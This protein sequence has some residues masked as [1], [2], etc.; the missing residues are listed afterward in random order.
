MKEVVQ[1]SMSL[2]ASAPSETSTLEKVVNGLEKVTTFLNN[3]THKISSLLLF[4]LMFL[5]TADVCG[6][7]FF[8]K[9]ITGT[10]ELTA[11]TL[12]VIIFFSLGMAQIK[13]DHI[14]IDFLTNKMPA[15]VQESLYALTS[16]ILFVLVALMGWQLFEFMNRILLGNELSGDL[17]MPL[18]IF[19]ALTGI[20]A[21]LFALTFLVDTLKS[22]LK[23]VKK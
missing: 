9:P 14:E 21:I 5:T 6:R 23:V 13:R 12:S 11:L 16:L 2:G 19:V 8:N 1:E 3:I 15:K 18:Y 4:F 22:I 10:Y 7:Y 17:G 20:G